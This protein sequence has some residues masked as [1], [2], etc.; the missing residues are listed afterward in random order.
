MLSEKRKL[1]RAQQSKRLCHY[2]IY[3]VQ[4]DLVVASEKILAQAVLLNLLASG[5]TQCGPYPC[6]ALLL[7]PLLSFEELA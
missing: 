7:C 2:V 4:E 5:C 1:G 3:A 6:S